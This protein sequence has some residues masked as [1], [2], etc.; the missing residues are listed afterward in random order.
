MFMM[1][2]VSIAAQHPPRK[3]NGLKLYLL[4]GTPVDS[5]L[6]GK[7]GQVA[8]WLPHNVKKVSQRDLAASINEVAVELGRRRDNSAGTEEL[9]PIYVMIY[10]LQRFRDLRKGDDDFGFSSSFGEQK[11]AS[12]GTQFSEILREGPPLGIHLIVWCDSVNNMNRT[13]DRNALRE[14]ELRV[15]FQMS[16]NDSSTVIDSPVAGKLG[17]NR[18]LFYSEEE[19]RIEKFR[20]YGLPDEEW[21]AEVKQK[22]AS[23]PAPVEPEPI[24]EPEPAPAP[25]PAAEAESTPAAGR[26]P[27]QRQRPWQAFRRR[28]PDVPRG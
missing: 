5:W 11:A 20:P 28:R 7:L 18:A 15:L 26:L 22:L 4:D 12:P 10:D 23:R 1:A 13:F 16:A 25:E 3:H 2:A 9:A 14:F 19:N 17:E 8:D 6:N 27:G 21:V 24:P